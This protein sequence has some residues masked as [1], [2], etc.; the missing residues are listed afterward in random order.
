VQYSP[1]TTMADTGGCRNISETSTLQVHES[2]NKVVNFHVDTLQHTL[3][4]WEWEAPPLKPAAL[5]GAF[6]RFHV[7]RKWYLFV[8]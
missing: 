1:F 3:L 7:Q 8:S 6:R 4:G 2:A 5:V